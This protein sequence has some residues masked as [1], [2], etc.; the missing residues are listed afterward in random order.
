MIQLVKIKKENK[1][2]AIMAG[3]F[4]RNKIALA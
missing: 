3:F 1:K 4:Y 2:P